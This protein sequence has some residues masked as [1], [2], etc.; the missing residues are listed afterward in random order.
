MMERR[1]ELGRWIAGAIQ[2]GTG[3]SVTLLLAGVVL[4]QPIVAWYGLLVLTL[5]P[6]LE[7][8]VAAVGFARAKELRYTLV[9]SVVLTLLLAGLA[10]AA[11]AGRAVGS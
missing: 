2:V 3:V 11:L 4:R 1:A 5:T 10:A 8:G 6:A 9:A 7:L